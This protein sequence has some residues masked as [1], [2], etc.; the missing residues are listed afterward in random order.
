[1]E[2][3]RDKKELKE[4]TNDSYIVFLQVEKKENK[5]YYFIIAIATP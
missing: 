3:L 4:L 2:I 5:L 1:M